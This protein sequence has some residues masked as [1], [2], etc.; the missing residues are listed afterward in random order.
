MKFW[1]KDRKQ[2]HLIL[3]WSYAALFLILSFIYDTK[4]ILFFYS[5][6][7]QILASIMQTITSIYAVL[8]VLALAAIISWKSRQQ[9]LLA[10][11][12]ITSLFL[13]AF[14]KYIIARPRPQ[15]EHLASAGGSAF[16][17]IHAAVLFAMI[18]FINKRYFSMKKM[19]IPIITLITASRLYLGVH[20]LSDLIFGAALGYTI[21]YI[22]IYYIGS[23]KAQNSEKN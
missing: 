21:S 9:L 23:R 19:L 16:P 15:V 13:S 18:P 6:R 4:I 7:N 11:S 10:L 3:F 17:S 14:L 8:I 22:Y 20:Y 2:K 12:L 5:I 1:I